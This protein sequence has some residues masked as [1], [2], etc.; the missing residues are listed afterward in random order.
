M[1]GQTSVNCHSGYCMVTKCTT[2]LSGH[3]SKVD[4]SLS[5][6]LRNFVYFASLQRVLPLGKQKANGQCPARRNFF[7]LFTF[8]PIPLP[9]KT[10]ERLNAKK[11]SKFY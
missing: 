9:L 2:L 8:S 4:T 5:E 1:S 6:P 3:L 11:I 7:V 10:P